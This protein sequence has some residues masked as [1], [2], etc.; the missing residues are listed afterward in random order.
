MSRNKPKNPN[1]A[2]NTMGEIHKKFEFVMKNL[3]VDDK[4]KSA[5]KLLSLKIDGQ[6]IGDIYPA[7]KF[8]SLDYE[9]TFFEALEVARMCVALDIIPV[10]IISRDKPDA[11]I[12][13]DGPSIF[14]E[15]RM[16]G[17]Q[18]EFAFNNHREKLN[19]VLHSFSQTDPLLKQAL[20][21]GLLQ[22]YVTDPG[23]RSW[24]K[25]P[26]IIRE[27]C[28]L[29]KTH[30][31]AQNDINGLTPEECPFPLLNRYGSTVFYKRKQSTSPLM[32]VFQSGTHRVD[33]DP[34]ETL[35]REAVE[36]KKKKAK[37]YPTKCS[38]LWL[39]LTLH[40]N[41]F[42]P[43]TEEKVKSILEGVSLDPFERI[44]IRLGGSSLIIL[45]KEKTDLSPRGA[46]VL[47]PLLS[48]LEE[49]LRRP[50]IVAN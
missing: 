17:D 34:L 27:I 1:I 47:R 40:E 29:L 49:L 38:P 22:I 10:D 28:S 39:L 37:D 3:G 6:L 35:I 5:Q 24:A 36:E 41:Y 20:D 26:D 31:T 15:Q 48:S 23:Q 50:H 14:V 43:F 42:S 8:N 2:S 9:T 32:I 16:I 46:S 25:H 44:V 33:L 12:V 45:S 18:N 13:L 21:N 19:A 4:N 11:E 7:L 30:G